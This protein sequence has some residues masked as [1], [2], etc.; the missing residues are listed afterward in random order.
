MYKSNEST[1]DDIISVT[2]REYYEVYIV[3]VVKYLRRRFSD[4]EITHMLTTS[5]TMSSSEFKK[6]LLEAYAKMDRKDIKESD[7][8]ACYLVF[9]RM[10]TGSLTREDSLLAAL[11]KVAPDKKVEELN[12]FVRNH[13][14]IPFILQ[15]NSSCEV[16]IDSDS[17]KITNI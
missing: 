8:L 10:L 15:E 7:M 1:A 9:Q 3:G 4:A 6:Y 13:V 5:L 16:G 14:T 17:N 11:L 2:L 12:N